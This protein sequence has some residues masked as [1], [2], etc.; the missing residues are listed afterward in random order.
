MADRTSVTDL[1]ERWQTGDDAAATELFERYRQ[2]LL[3]R[4]N[5]GLGAELRRQ[6]EPADILLSVFTSF[7][8]R[9]R[10]GEYP[11]D[12][13]TSLWNLLRTITLNKI[14]HQAEHHNAQKRDIGREISLNDLDAMV[15]PAA[16]GPT[17]DAI[18]ILA[19][20]IASLFPGLKPVEADMIQLFLEVVSKR[21]KC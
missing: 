11:I 14:R 9:S 2:P 6:V 17:P 20:E 15:E 7:F 4:V 21:K 5:A 19:D 13:T 16:N 1:I 8:R 3:A 18:V 10:D 12:S